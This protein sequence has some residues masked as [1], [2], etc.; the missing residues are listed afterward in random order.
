MELSLKNLA[1]SGIS[2]WKKTKDKQAT[3]TGKH[4]L[5]TYSGY[6]SKWVTGGV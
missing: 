6:K 1:Q 2:Q 4:K 3:I 5:W